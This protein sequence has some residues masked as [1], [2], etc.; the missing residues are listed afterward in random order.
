MSR[1]EGLRG[2]GLNGLFPLDYDTKEPALT[3]IPPWPSAGG[4]KNQKPYDQ[5]LVKDALL[6]P[7]HYRVAP[8]DLNDTNLRSTQ[9]GLTRAGVQH[10][11][12]EAYRTHGTLYSDVHNA[13]NQ[14]PM[15]YHR[16]DGI[17]LLLSGHHRAAAA[18]LGDL[19]LNAIHVH[20]PWGAKRG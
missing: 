16:D 19:P 1:I 15:V 4:R 7:D 13:G 10:Y 8:Q 12:G 11:M 18:L 2:S 9:P 3:S 14:R 17:S 20:G 6:N 5:G